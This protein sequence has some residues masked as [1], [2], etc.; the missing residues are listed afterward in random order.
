MRAPDRGQRPPSAQTVSI[1]FDNGVVANFTLNSN[2]HRTMRSVRVDGTRG[3]AWGELHALDGWLKVADHRS[4]RVRRVKVPTAY[5]GHGGGEAPLFIEFLDAIRNG[6][7]PSVSAAESL[8]AT[9]S[10]SPPWNLPPVA[11]WSSS[12]LGELPPD[13]ADR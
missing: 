8:E 3:T 9:G 13:A 5:D 12:R 7:E 1:S 11:G 4:G 2:S 6:H 10:R